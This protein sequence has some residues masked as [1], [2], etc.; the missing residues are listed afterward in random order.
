MQDRADPAQGAAPPRP[1]PDH[2]SLHRSGAWR[3]PAGLPP[4]P[5]RPVR[6]ATAIGFSAMSSRFAASDIA[7]IFCG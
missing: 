5:H 2:P 3:F 7:A 1:T 6:G 4:P